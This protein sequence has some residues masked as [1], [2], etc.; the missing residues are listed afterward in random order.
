VVRTLHRRGP[1]VLATSASLHSSQS[2]GLAGPIDRGHILLGSRASAVPFGHRGVFTHRLGPSS[3][4]HARPPSRTPSDPPGCRRPRGRAR[5]RAMHGSSDHPPPDGTATVKL[6]TRVIITILTALC[7][8]SFGMI[9]YRSNNEFLPSVNLVNLTEQI[10][11]LAPTT[12]PWHGV[13]TTGEAKNIPFDRKR[14]GVVKVSLIRLQLD[15]TE[16]KGHKRALGQ[17]SLHMTICDSS[18]A[19]CQ[20]RQIGVGQSFTQDV[21][22]ASGHVGIFNFATSPRVS[23]EISITYTK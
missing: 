8:W 9:Y 18:G 15:W 5:L 19:N 16:W 6:R 11:P 22:D 13:L 2:R 14:G 21:A 20:R 4:H 10:W 12:A 1:A 7:F 23:V 3:A 17:D